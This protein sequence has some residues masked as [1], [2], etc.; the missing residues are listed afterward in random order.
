[1]LAVLSAAPPRKVTLTTSKPHVTK[2]VKVTIVNLGDQPETITDLNMLTNVV[3]LSV[4]SLGACPAPAISLVPPKKGFPVV[5]APKK[6]LTLVYNVI[7]DCVNDA[8][9]GAGHEDFRYT[10]TIDTTALDGRTDIQPSDNVCP[11][12]PNPATGDEGCGAKDPATKHLGAAIL[13]D[14]IQKP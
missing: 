6:K 11:R 12:P 8:A 5:L 4:E 7:F 2:P 14:V 10:V 3:V 9:A 13:T 1:D